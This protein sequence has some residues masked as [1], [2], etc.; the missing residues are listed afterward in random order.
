[1]KLGTERVHHLVHGPARSRP[2]IVRKGHR[3]PSASQPAGE[4]AKERR[5]RE[6]AGQGRAQEGREKPKDADKADGEAEGP[7][8]G[9]GPY[10]DKQL[11]K[12]LEVIRAKSPSRSQGGLSA[13]V[14]RTPRE[15]DWRARARRHSR[16]NVRRSR[17]LVLLAI[18]TT[19][20]ET[21]AAVLEGPRPP[22]AGRAA[23]SLQRRR[24][25]GRPA[26]AISAAWSP[27]SPR[28]PTSGQILPMID[29]A[30][31][32]AGVAL[33]DLGAVA[34]ATRPGLVGALV[35]GLTAAKALALALD[36]PLIAVDHLE[37]HLYACQLAY[38]DRDVYPCVG[39][40]RLG[41][42]H[43]PLSLPAVRSIANF[44]A[45]RPTTRRAKRSIKSRACSAWAIPAG[46]RSSGRPNAGNPDGI[47]LSPLIPARRTADLELLGPED[48]RAVRA[49][50]PERRRQAAA[51]LGEAL[52]RDLA[53]SFQ[54]AVVDVVVAKTRQAL[55][56]TGMKRL[57]GRGAESRRIPGFANGWRRWRPNSGSNCSS[58]RCRSA[59]TTPPWPASRCPSSPPARSPTSTSTSRPGWSG[60]G[61]GDDR[62]DRPDRRPCWMSH[63]GT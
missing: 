48:G 34:V 38:P 23:D 57:G 62:R 2:G 39:P 40:G 19:C 51:E 25:A 14:Q 56:R 32:R 27:R 28:E 49:A 5:R 37:G 46:R 24:L 41:R 13:S 52:I 8:D 1:M 7:R 20:D 22:R 30:L 4:K 42:P 33:G 35:V 50:R 17:G 10:V 6:A 9:A 26:S 60:R 36:I 43:E 31:R 11:D 54:E 12:A 29:E 44:W 58:R 53:A 55:L 18:E 16:P 47:R 59:P 61:V 45:A 15:I 63:A 3:K 21:A